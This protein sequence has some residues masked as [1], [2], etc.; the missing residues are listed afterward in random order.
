MYHQLPQLFYSILLNLVA[1]ILESKLHVRP[2]RTYVASWLLRT[3]Q[4]LRSRI[5]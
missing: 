1:I 3:S 5:T 2:C 4:V